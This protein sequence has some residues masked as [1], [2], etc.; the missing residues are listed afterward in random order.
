VSAGIVILAA[1]QGRRFGGAKQLHPV[2]GRPMLE[3]VLAAA[4]RS[5][6][7]ERIVVLGAHGS[8][9][10]AAVDLH[11]A[12]VVHSSAWREGQA[13]S[14]RAGLDELS[15][16]D[17]VVVLGDGPALDVRAIARVLAAQ[18]PDH[19][20][21]LAADYGCGRSHP[22]VLPRSFWPQLPRQGESPGRTLA[23]ELVDCR[24]LQAPGDVDYPD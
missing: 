24:D 16:D 2:D 22:V 6:I 15:A 11:G 3:A 7:D 4:E 23:V 1:G 19:P 13:A 20:R 14:L 12:R 21:P 17:A 9:V 18:D 8:A 5:G 10:L